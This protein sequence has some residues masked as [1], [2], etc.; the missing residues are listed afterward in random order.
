MRTIPVV[1]SNLQAVGYDPARR[2]LRVV[3]KS[4]AVH[5][6]MGVGPEEHSAL[7]AADSHGKHYN[8]HIKGRYAS[9]KAGGAP[10]EDEPPQEGLAESFHQTNEIRPVHQAG[11]IGRT[12]P[13]SL[14]AAIRRFSGNG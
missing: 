2:E 4:G 3:F 14:D 13:S 12:Q 6:H 7:M 5:D 9:L 1:S 8:E 10:M 11:G